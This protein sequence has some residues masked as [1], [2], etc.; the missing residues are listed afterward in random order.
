MQKR[1]DQQNFAS[2]SQKVRKNI[3]NMFLHG[4]DKK[5]G[6]NKVKKKESFKGLIIQCH[7]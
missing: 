7:V 1:H 3:P 6:K 2:E 5:K 4:G